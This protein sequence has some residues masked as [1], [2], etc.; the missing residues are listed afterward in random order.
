MEKPG[1]LQ[2]GEG[3]SLILTPN[4][5][6]DTGPEQQPDSL[7]GGAPAGLT[8]GADLPVENVSAPFTTNGYAPDPR[9][10]ELVVSG[11]E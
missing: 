7:Q 8:F 5:G 6:P 4:R 1:F 11:K 3:R 9:R 2:Q 10:D